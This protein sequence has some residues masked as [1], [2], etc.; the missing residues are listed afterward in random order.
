MAY[1]KIYHI[2]IENDTECVLM[3]EEM[4]IL[5]VKRLV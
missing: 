3:V 2:C 4:R 5:E 1:N